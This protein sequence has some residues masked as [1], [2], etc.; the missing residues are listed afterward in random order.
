MKSNK[1]HNI[2]VNIHSHK[3][4]LSNLV[5]PELHK[6]IKN[7]IQSILYI[8]KIDNTIFFTCNVMEKTID[9]GNDIIC[10]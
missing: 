5:H 9:N 6:W 1:F 2:N 4:K 10:S 7:H 8:K 3:N